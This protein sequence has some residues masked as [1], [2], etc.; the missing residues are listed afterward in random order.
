VKALMDAHRGQIDVKSDLGK[1]STFILTFPYN[2][3]LQTIE[4]ED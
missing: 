2:S 1:G 4:I 3:E